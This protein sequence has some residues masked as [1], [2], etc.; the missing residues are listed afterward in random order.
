[1][2]LILTAVL[3]LALLCTLLFHYRRKKI[4]QKLA[5]MTDADKCHLLQE[6][7]APL[8]YC[9]DCCQSVFGSQRDAWQKDFGYTA[10]YD[11]LA[12]Y[13]H[14]VFDAQPVFF[15][16][17]GRTW[18]IEFWKGQYGITTGAEIGVYYAD[19]LIPPEKRASTL[20]HAASDAMLPDIT[21]ILEKQNTTL[22]AFNGPHW[23]QTAFLVGQY[24]SPG[25]LTLKTNLSFPNCEMLS[26]FIRALL[27]LGYPTSLLS[28]CGH[29]LSFLYEAPIP[30]RESVGRRLIKKLELFRCRV[31]CRIYQALVR[32]LTC[33]TDQL[34]FLYF[35]LPGCFRRT[36][37]LHVSG[38][39]GRR[40]HRKQFCSCRH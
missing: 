37:R 30:H 14:M 8:G 4:L 3:L 10:A 17:A 35:C 11:R 40:Q 36:F 19:G 24:S 25:E 28:T 2:Y 29:R 31:L 5:S 34:L 33:T 26:A 7:C 38:R 6:L 15:D 27:D 22:A 23:W 1:M 9:Y 20:F 39:S 13:F 18:L 16:Y 12:P 21:L 32:P